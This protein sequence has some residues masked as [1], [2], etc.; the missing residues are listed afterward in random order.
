MKA[1][2]AKSGGRFSHCV[3]VEL[4]QQGK[5]VSVM[6]EK[7]FEHLSMVA[8]VV[9]LSLNV[10]DANW[11]LVFMLIWVTTVRLPMTEELCSKLNSCRVCD[12]M[13]TSV[14]DQL[15]SFPA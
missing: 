6:A 1:L 9:V 3:V 12:E 13:L 5:V 14:T 10:I 2:N 15:P 4:F 8:M 11:Q 7:L